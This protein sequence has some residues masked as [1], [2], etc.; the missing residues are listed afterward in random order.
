MLGKAGGGRPA[1][2]S[3][4]RTVITQNLE[5]NENGVAYAKID[6]DLIALNKRFVDLI[7]MMLGRIYLHWRFMIGKRLVLRITMKGNR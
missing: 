6:H 7:D 4:D 3:P 2:I 5:P 1:T